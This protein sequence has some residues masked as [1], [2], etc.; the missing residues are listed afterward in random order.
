MG[1]MVLE[2]RWC[3]GNEQATVTVVGSRGDTHTLNYSSHNPGPYQCNWS[4]TCKGFEHRGKCRHI[5]QAEKNRCDYGWEAAAGSPMPDD[6]WV[7]DDKCCPKCGE[8][9]RA[10]RYAV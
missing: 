3:V 1:L 8:P 2:A 10:M 5:D 9:S 4:C 6:V 7:G